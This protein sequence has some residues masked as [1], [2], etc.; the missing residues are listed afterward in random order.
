MT[1][2]ETSSWKGKKHRIDDRGGEKVKEIT[3]PPILCLFF[4]EDTMARLRGSAK[5]PG[6]SQPPLHELHRT[7]IVLGSGESFE[8]D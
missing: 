7:L 2:R 8:K 3:N 6:A 1:R 4:F 5:P